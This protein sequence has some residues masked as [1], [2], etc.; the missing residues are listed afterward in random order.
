MKSVDSF[1]RRNSF[2]RFWLSKIDVTTVIRMP[3]DS[4]FY[5]ALGVPGHQKLHADAV[6]AARKR[7][8]PVDYY[9]FN[10]VSTTGGFPW[11]TGYGW[12]PKNAIIQGPFPTGI[13]QHELGHVMGLPHALCWLSPTT[14]GAG[15][16][17]YGNPFDNMGYG[18]DFSANYK[19]QLGWIPAGN[20]QVVTHSGTYRIYAMDSGT[21]LNNTNRYAI[22]IPGRAVNHLGQTTDYWIECRS[23]LAPDAKFKDNSVTNGVLILWG[24]AQPRRD[25]DLLDMTPGSKRGLQDMTDAALV[26]GKTF[27]D[28]AHHLT[29]TTL[30]RDGEGPSS[31][32]DVMVEISR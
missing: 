7:G 30:T 32:A 18:G 26:V 5:K 16:E 8:I 4:G 24:N 28:A 12:G 27:N 11:Q 3:Q 13:M 19:Y 29:I 15:K 10:I 21:H 25:N 20:L 2:G 23:Q 14:I 31:Y 9:D 22:C 6:V 1:H 17:I